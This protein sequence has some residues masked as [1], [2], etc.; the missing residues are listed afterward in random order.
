MRRLPAALVAGV[1]IA[2]IGLGATSAANATT[3]HSVAS[4]A[5][6]VGWNG[7]LNSTNGNR[8]F[9]QFPKVT[10]AHGTD[11]GRLVRW[12]RLADNRVLLY[13]DRVDVHVSN[14]HKTGYTNT[15][16]KLRRY[17]VTPQTKVELDSNN[18]FW[19]TGNPTKFHGVK[20]VT[21][22]KFLQYLRDNS[23]AAEM[24]FRSDTG[25]R[26]HFNAAHNTITKIQAIAVDG[27]PVH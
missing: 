8:Y 11:N 16:P 7:T 4:A 19:V 22:H 15:N 9:A 26:L 24:G 27:Q 17:F 18:Y 14:H 20:P 12:T 5:K 21:I 23:T 10:P 6:H 1:A 2:G 13:E 25:Y 3:T